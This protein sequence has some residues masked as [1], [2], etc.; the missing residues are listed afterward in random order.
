MKEL[1]D[2]LSSYNLFN[3]L[4]PGTLFVATAQRIS[5]HNFNQDNIVVTLF[6]YYFIGLVIS[7]LGSLVVEPLLTSTKFVKFA[8]YQKFIGAC[9]ADPKIELL[10]EQNNLYRTLCALFIAL[11]AFKGVDVL[12]GHFAWPDETIGTVGLFT[13]FVLFAFAYRK[14]TA[15]VRKRVEARTK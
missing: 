5:D 13:L 14:Q 12:A 3:Y 9:D 7:R 4:L 8:P 2:K 1:L 15:Y 10:S 6:V 11:P